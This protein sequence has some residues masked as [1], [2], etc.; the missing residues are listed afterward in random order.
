MA[1]LTEAQRE[2][3][4]AAVVARAGQREAP[5]D[6]PLDTFSREYFRQVDP[7]DLDERTPEDL[8][9]ALLSHWQ[10]ASQRTPGVP[11]VRVFSPSPGA[12]GWGSRHSV[13]QVVNDDMPFLV[14]S[15][16]LEIARQGL[17]LHL[18]VHPIFAVRRDARGVLQSVAPRSAAPELPRE[19]W[20]YIEVD[21]MVD[22]E[23]RTALCRGIERVLA[24][25]RA[26]VADW[27]PM[28]ERLT[29]AQ[30]SLQVPPPGMAPEE[31]A[32]SRAFLQW[33]AEDHFT[34][35]GFRR[36]DLVERDGE[37]ALQLVEGSGLGVLREGHGEQSASFA[38]LPPQ[39]RALARTPTP[40]V[41]VTKANTRSTVHRD[42]YTDYVGVKRFDADGRV[43]GEDRFIGL[44]TSTAYAS[45]VTEVPLLRRKVEAVAQRAGLSPTGHLAKALQ[46]TLEIFPRDDLFQIADE[47]LYDTA[48]GILAL[49]ERHRLRLFLWQ[50]RFQ[51]FVSCLVF[52]PRDV[53]STQLRLKFQR[54]LLQALNGTHV[55]F[56]VLLSGTQLARIHFTVRVAPNPMPAIDRKDLERKLAAAA[57]RWEDELRDA[58][59]EAEGEGNGLALDRRWSGAFPVAYR[60]RI[61]V[62]A[63]VHDIRKL[64][65]LTEQA[66]MAVALY[67]PL[68]GPEGRLGLKVYRLGAPVVLSDS[69]PMLEHM[70]V[71][72]LAEDNHRIET[73]G[74]PPMFLHDFALEA[75]PGAEHDPQALARLFEDAFVRVFRGEVEND[76]FNR[77]VLLSALS[78]EEI[79]ILRAYAKYLQQIGFPQSQ[80]TIA[81]TLATYPRIARML[82]ALFRLRFDAQAHDTQG[83]ASQ[84]NALEQALEKVANLNEDR[85]LRQLLALL[86]ATLRTNYWRTGV[87]ASGAPGPRRPFLSFKFD[88][89][90]IPGLPAPRPLYEIWVY[91]PRFEGIHLRG[92][93]VARGGLRWS[94]RPDDFRTEVLGLVKAQMVK[95]TVIVPVGSK[96]G[97]VLKKAPPASDREAFMKEGVACY[98]DYLRGLLDLTDNLVNGKTVPPPQV[99]RIDGDDPYLVVAAD[100]GTASFSDHANAVSAEYGHWLG[101]AFASGGSK[102]YD[103]KAMG[104]TARGAWE[105]VKRHFRELGVD[106]QSTDFTV[107]GIGDMSG[108]VFGN[109]MLLSRHIRL[110]AAFDHRHVFIDPSPDAERTFAERE[111]L[112]QLPRS[113]WAD[114][115]RNLISEGG[116]IWARSEKSVPLSPQ[117]RAAL[118][119]EAEQMTP[120]ELVTAILKA[121]VDLLYN[122]GIGTYVKASSETHAEVGDRAND[123]VRISGA[124]LRCKVVAEGGNLGFTQRGRIE[125]ALAGVKINTDAIDNSAGVDTSDHE[126]NIKILLGIAEADG[127]LTPRQRDTLLPQMTEQ[128]AALVLRD[129][130]FQTQALSVGGR[131]AAKQLDEQARFIRFL[132]KAGELDRAIEYLPSEE[133][134]AARLAKGQGLT[135][136]ERAVLLAYGKMWLNDALVA[137]DL[138]EDP[139]I[140]TALERYFPTQLKEKFAALIPRHP[141]RREI[142]ATHVLNSMVNRVGP[143]FVH[144]LGEITGATPPQVVRAYLASREV[145]GLVALWQ[146]IEA[147]DTLVPDEVQA[148]MVIAL[149]GLL[150]RATT[151][152]LRSRRLFEPTEQQVGRFAPVVQAL[153]TDGARA[154]LSPRA[155][156]WVDAGV[157]RELAAQVDASGH[158]FS[159]LDIAEIAEAG[160]R[161]VAL[162][163]QVH[164]GV[165]ERLG[166]E[167]MR[168][169]VEQ[170]PADSYWQGLAKLALADDVTDLQRS[171]AQEA[172]RHEEGD[173][174]QVL[175]RWEQGNRQALER[176]QRLLAELKDAPGGD[177]AM[178]S[179]ALRELRNLV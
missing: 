34:L 114:Y 159:A 22:A 112:F 59:V 98:Q 154:D 115:D 104:I 37:L 43:I 95:N 108:D 160:K 18:L 120:A 56:D 90:R 175:E 92:G 29:E 4:L 135:S 169:Q 51:R 41:V 9:G 39:A 153:R 144:R 132:E 168:Q 125:A 68:G 137:S 54:I 44:F 130:Y 61:P 99:V 66:P 176:A 111:R 67:W 142:I 69:L 36:H 72:V 106:T 105:S 118:G 129:N 77:L 33:M 140:A 89:A 24:D 110:V 151:W 17:A 55:D 172:V 27:K 107:V 78:A 7:E 23:Q 60:E 52:V 20:M 53:F 96:G 148:E 178:L 116:G 74:H 161:P 57:R 91:S 12:D 21:R 88:S 138:P 58:L 84:V 8:L 38:A 85:V 123:A 50:D 63:A 97:F 62:R 128:V 46:H 70:G 155:Q 75:Q 47:D 141:L 87:G 131:L 102:G 6:V 158:L 157:P 156:R 143:T 73:A 134:I 64:E 124:E 122:G 45:R 83:A 31:A 174:R 166:L 163:A 119:I 113:S 173:A 152:F 25:V 146:Q 11:K 139:W 28:L 2:E 79:V 82:V 170:L 1:A 93:K 80:A 177:L 32:E 86:Q 42:G 65:S 48:M 101:D 30:A 81:A 127:E 121:P 35:L 136:P 167:R 71:R 14:D 162:T 26:A 15:V 94:D 164:Q 165:G 100:K 117:A 145:F 103:H 40:A 5:K 3:R 10:F 149:R 49:G 13:V 171:I 126:V 150:T 179:V 16:S 19:S 147:L 133:E 109:G 76:S